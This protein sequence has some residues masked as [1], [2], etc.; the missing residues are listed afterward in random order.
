MLADK[1]DQVNVDELR[2]RRAALANR[3]DELATL[4]TEG[5]LDGPAV[6]R[7]SGKLS[8]KI[9]DIDTALAEAARR[10]PGLCY[11]CELATSKS[12]TEGK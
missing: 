6:R 1:H 12:P 3:K 11:W 8:A 10:N 7:E 9:A 4:F 2:T 5:V